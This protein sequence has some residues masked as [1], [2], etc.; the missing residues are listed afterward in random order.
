[1]NDLKKSTNNLDSTITTEPDSYYKFDDQTTLSQVPNQ[2]KSTFISMNNNL[3]KK[4]EQYN[5]ALKRKISSEVEE[6]NPNLLQINEQILSS[7]RT[8][9]IQ[10]EFRKSAD[11][12]ITTMI[13]DCGREITIT[14]T[15]NTLNPN[16]NFKK[17]KIVLF[18]FTHCVSAIYYGYHMVCMNNLGTPIMKYGMNI[19]DKTEISH[20]LGSVTLA[21][22]IGKMIGSI[23][24]GTLQKSYGKRLV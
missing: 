10:D 2:E 4:A 18:I 17:W 3:P 19:T 12:H 14:Y 6:P 24:G 1:M 22:G 20:M 21:F 8:S 23:L 16:P 13:H 9:D 15:N 11:N 7:K 5:S